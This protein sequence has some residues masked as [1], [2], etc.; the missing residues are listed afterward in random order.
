MLVVVSFLV[1]RVAVNWSRLEFRLF[2]EVDSIVCWLIIIRINA[3]FVVYVHLCTIVVEQYS[4]R[5]F[6]ATVYV[7]TYRVSTCSYL[8]ALASVTRSA[9]C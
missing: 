4:K 3:T 2:Y 9:Y 5:V 7:Y 8:F 1:S 6:V